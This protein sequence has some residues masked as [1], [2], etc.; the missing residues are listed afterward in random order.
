[1]AN[2]TLR[3][4]SRQYAG[5]ETRA[6][7]SLDLDVRDGEL[8]V[9]VGPSGCGKS[10]ALRLIAGLDAPDQGTILIGDR[11]VSRVPPQD[12]DVA[13]VFQGYALYPHLTV[14]DNLA[15]PLKMR[16]VRRDERARR[17]GSAAS[18]LGLSRLLDRLPTE[19][20]GGERQRVAM[21]RAIVRAPRVFLFDEPLSNLDAALRA[22]LRD[23]IAALVRRLGTTSLYVTHDQVEAM[24]M[25][26][27][28]AI[29][30]SGILQQIGTPRQ[31]YENP[32]NAFVAGFLGSPAMNWIE[33]TRDGD[34]L[35]GAGAI[36]PAPEGIALPD[37]IKLG[38][39][40]EHLHFEQARDG[41]PAIAIDALVASTEPHGAETQLLVEAAATRLR[42][43]TPGFD[44]PSPGASVR[45][46]VDPRKIFWFDGQSGARLDGV[47]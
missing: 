11:D 29:L 5:A 44:A 12:R 7:A 2:V 46:Y 31:I 24:T 43:K 36:F 20:S 14:R 22:E 8:L 6:L 9:L 30:S 3:G 33:L 38:V 17:V 35:E 23:E 28:I 40:P 42:A 32:V 47:H 1:M 26:D 25:G 10:T 15:F 34:R 21:G 19:L 18:M 4:L 39:R 27:R 45:L 16:G 41:A 13:M 37:R